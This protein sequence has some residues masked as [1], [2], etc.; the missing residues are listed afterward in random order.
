[1]QFSE[2]RL[3]V[4]PAFKYTDGYD[5]VPDS[6]RRRWLRTE[7]LGFATR[8]TEVNAAMGSLFVPLVKMIKGWNREE[9][10]PIRSFHLECLMY[11]RY[12]TDS[13]GSRTRQ[14]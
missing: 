10:W 1:M 8:I 7:S 2:F 4:V 9:G 12:R 6:V 14:W 3:D 5:S 13:K 11:E